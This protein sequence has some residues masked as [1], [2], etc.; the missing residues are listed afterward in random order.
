MHRISV[1]LPG[2]LGPSQPTQRPGIT[3]KVTS[4]TAVVE[5]KRFDTPRA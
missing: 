1:V 4:L 5:P 2:L 3:W